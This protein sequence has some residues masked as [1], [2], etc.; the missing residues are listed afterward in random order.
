MNIDDIAD[1]SL[2]LHDFLLAMGFKLNENDQ[3]AALH[4]FLQNRLDKF[5][6]EDINY[7]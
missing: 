6:T 4:E 3:Y 1:L 5:V 7:N 2:D